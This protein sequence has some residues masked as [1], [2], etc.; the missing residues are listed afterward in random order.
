VTSAAHLE[1]H[2]ER[3]QE[4]HFVHLHGATWGDYQRLL[5][6]RGDRSA[7]RITYLEGE[8]EIMT[9][10]RTH[11]SIKSIIGCL[12]EVWCFEQGIEFSKYGSWTLESQE[13][14]RGAEP[15]ECYVFGEVAEPTRPDLAI[16]VVWTSGGIDKLEVYRKL[17]VREVWYWRRGTI[18]P[19]A[20]RG[21]R[22]EAIPTSEVLPGID[23]LLLAGFLDR[24]TTSRAIREYRLALKRVSGRDPEG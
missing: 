6:I 20:L 7:P 4:D 8:L 2:D 15:D 17:G 18:Q 3:R 23:L 5:R 11:E 19:Y 21:E 10:S 16:E 24:K 12:V 14:E 9:P 13:S 22:Y 1:F